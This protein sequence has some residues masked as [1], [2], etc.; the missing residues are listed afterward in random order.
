LFENHFGTITPD[1]TPVSAKSDTSKASHRKDLKINLHENHFATI[2][3]AD[4][5]EV[6][7]SENEKY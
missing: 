6:E 5:Y 7:T 4:F 3:S 2:T 1:K